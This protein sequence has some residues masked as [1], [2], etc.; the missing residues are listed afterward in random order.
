MESNQYICQVLW[1]IKDKTDTDNKKTTTN[2]KNGTCKK[3]RKVKIL[4]SGTNHVW[5]FVGVSD[6]D[7]GQLDVKELVNGVQCAADAITTTETT[8]TGLRTAL[9][10]IIHMSS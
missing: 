9:E 2:L 10:S 3:R 7:V 5:I 6:T 8:I 1:K 4:K